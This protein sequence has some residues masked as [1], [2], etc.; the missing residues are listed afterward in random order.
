MTPIELFHEARLSEAIA[1]QRQIVERR[2]DDIAQRLLLC[3]LLAFAGDHS[4]LRRQLEYLTKGPAEIREYVAEWHE[5]LTA[6]GARHAGNAPDFLIDP[7]EHVLRRLRAL[8]E[9]NAGHG[10]RAL[11][12]LDDADEKAP[13]I[14]G[15]V[16]GRPFE[17]W[18]DTD[19]VLGPVLELLGGGLWIWLAMDQVRKL[20]LEQTNELRDHIYRPA[21][22]WLCDGNVHELF[23]PVLYAGTAE[24]PEE[25]IRTGAGIDWIERNG[26]MRGLGSR[27]YLFGEEELTVDEFRQVEIR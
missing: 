14:E 5:I 1:G 13:W 7:P 17:G 26:L 8:G 18:R 9:L 27:T 21:T 16:D 2:P 15:H 10:D 3:D 25:G 23:I 12:L 11:D 4:E 20:R 24:H 6:D 19:D 22:L